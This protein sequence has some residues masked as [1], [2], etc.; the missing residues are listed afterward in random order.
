MQWQK[1]ILRQQMTTEKDFLLEIGCEEIPA[2]FLYPAGEYL[3]KKLK[4][5]FERKKVKFKKIQKFITPRRIAVLVEDLEKHTQREEV[6]FQGPPK[7]IAFTEDGKLTTAGLKFLKAKDASF[8][9]SFIKNTPKGEYLFVKKV[10]GGE[11]TA[12]ILKEELKKII[13]SIP[14]QKTMRW[15]GK[16]K[17][18]RP[19][20][21]IVSLFEDEVI[22]FE[23]AGIKSGRKTYPNRNLNKKI[24]IKKPKDYEK[25]L[26]ENYVIV[27]YEK[28]RKILY[29]KLSKKAKSLHGELIENKELL[30][31]VTNLV[32]YPRVVSCEFDKR[33]TLLPRDVLV[34]AL[35]K[36]QKAFSVQDEKG[37]LKT[38]FL[39]VLNNPFAVDEKV[40]PW[41]ERMVVSRL[42]DALFYMEEDLKK[43][44]YPLVEEEKNVTWI[45]GLGTLYNKTERLLKLGEEFVKYIP[46]ASISKYKKAA[47]LS[48]ADL[49]TNLVREKEFTSLQGTAGKEYLLKLG[50]DK[51]IAQAVE[52]QYLPRFP[53]DTLPKTPEGALLSILDKADN[54]YAS[55]LKGEI[56]KG[57]R[58]PFGL[59]RQM[60]GI[61]MIA[62]SRKI[63]IPLFEI[64]D[65]IRKLFKKDGKTLEK[66]KIF[67]KERERNFL[68]DKGFKYDMVDAVLAV[69]EDDIYDAFLRVSSL[70]DI[71]K[72]KDFEKLVIGQKRIS[73]I[74]KG[75]KAGTKINKDLLEKKE[76]IELFE[77]A[78]SIEDRIKESIEKK[79]YKKTIQL[80]ISLRE[81]IDRFFD[82]VFVMTE[83]K[84]IRKNRLALLQYLRTLF[85]SFA[86]L[87]KIAM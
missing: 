1:N 87:S 60:T 76:E 3:E 57:S 83:N 56:P 81:Y 27:S 23:V 37:G 77:K 64:F 66:I 32:E 38:E 17:F 67:I 54:I 7:K 46:G 58:D 2:S 34:T 51:R 86:D 80:L 6:E 20:R 4:E 59:R 9:D 45:E 19:I 35:A 31:E 8:K 65:R 14:F 18:A 85:I 24:E 52:D 15:N 50:E 13:L 25:L 30:D 75:V 47:Y 12:Q 61:L 71:E 73:N 74:L 70:K 62:L 48:K 22:E 69:V 28:R 40:K 43:G 36:H 16:E 29:E 21:W 53:E 39:V 11:K 5:L 42:D 41:F 10:V 79:R 44:I 63:Y 26:E 84:K 82:N 55:F 78:K 49:L 72:D 68:M 33:F